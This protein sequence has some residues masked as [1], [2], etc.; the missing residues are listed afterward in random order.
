MLPSPTLKRRAL[1][2]SLAALCTL[3]ALSAL[4]RPSAVA[5][6]AAVAPCA[7]PAFNSA[8]STGDAGGGRAVAFADFN[9][10]G[11]AD[12]AEA[13]FFSQSN[14]RI[15]LGDGAGKFVLSSQ[16]NT[17]DGSLDVTS[18]DFNRDGRADLAVTNNFGST[19]S[20][21]LG[22]GDGTFGPHADFAV[23][24]GPNKL[25][26]GDF[27]G[28]QK[29]DLITASFF[30]NSVTVL[31]GDGAGG[32]S[33]ATTAVVAEPH[34]LAVGDFNGDQKLDAAAAGVTSHGVTV[35]LGNGAGRLTRAPDSFGRL[36][37]VPAALAAVDA[38]ADGRL[39][40]VVANSD[41]RH[42]TVWKGDGAGRFGS[43]VEHP[44]GLSPSAVLVSDLDADGRPDLFVTGGQSATVSVL[45]GKPGGGFAPERRYTV[46]SAP[47]A[48]ALADLNND[49]RTDA[50]VANFASRFLSV[51]LADPSGGFAAAP[52]FS[53][54]PV[55]FDLASAAAAADFNRD[56]KADLA[57]AI[58]GGVAVVLADG[59]GGFAPGPHLAA[60][61]EGDL[62]AADFNRDGKTD[63]AV[64]SGPGSPGSVSVFLGDGAGDFA[65]RRTFLVDTSPLALA[66]ADFNNDGFPD[67]ATQTYGGDAASVL[68]GDGAGG[69]EVRPVNN[70]GIQTPD[71]VAG[72]FNSDGKADLAAT[73]KF[74]DQVAVV[75]GDGAGNFAP[76]PASPFPVVGSPEALAVDDFN[77]DGRAD[78]L[79]A[80]AHSGFLWANGLFL[81]KNNG[82]GGFAA[83]API[84]DVP[85]T[86]VTAGDFNGDGH[87]DF[88]AA[89]GAQLIVRLGNGRGNFGQPFVTPPGRSPTDLDAA[90]MD[91]DG[92]ADL[93]TA[94]GSGDVTVFFN[95]CAAP[96]HAF[97]TL[98]AAGTLTEGDAGTL[99]GTLTFSLSAASTKTVSAG[100]YLVSGTAALGADFRPASGRLIFSPG[101]TTKT[102]SVAVIG[103][104]LDESD[105]SLAVSFSFPLNVVA[106]TGAAT[107]LDNDPAPSAS[108][109]D[110][111]APEG[112]GGAAPVVFHVSLSAPSSRPVSVAY[113]TADGTAQAGA[114]YVATSG[115]LTIRPG[116]TQGSIPVPVVGDG[117][118]EADETF[119][120]NLTAP[121]GVTLADAQGRAT[122]T[123]DDTNVQ[124]E[125][126]GASFAE[127]VGAVAVRVT[128]TGFLSAAS[129][130]RYTTVD[131]GAAG[132]S[133]YIAALGELRFAPDEA[134]KTLTVLVV[135][136]VWAEGPES[137]KVVLSDPSG[138]TLGAASEF[139]A[140]I[141]SDDASTGPSPVG[142]EGFDTRF[143]VTQ[144][145]LDFLNRL[146]DAGGLS[147]WSR[148]ITGC[149]ADRQCVAV[150]RV[151]TSAAFFLSIEFQETGYLVYRM[152][153]AAYGDA[154]SPGVPGTVPVVRLEEFLP[155]TRRI[156]EGVVVGAAGWAER[157]EANKQSFA[158]EFVARPRFLAAYPA[159]LTPAQF[160]DRLDQRA[161]GVLT[162]QE[163]TQL[164]AQLT[165][166]NPA[167]GRAAALRA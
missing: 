107:I 26:R 65:P 46:G 151:D 6:V 148:G 44:A 28:D 29:T 67:L 87:P 51:L 130:V 94:N 22:N 121:A 153:K 48:A 52:N 164:I 134:T 158:Q 92:R 126:A 68:L 157:L 63:L 62:A 147:F 61:A 111:A 91:G 112:T 39:D 15:H 8:L 19:I 123:N 137:F 53:L 103:D 144:H 122:I 2:V 49:G 96:P 115:T 100:Y 132:R 25:A 77:S 35:L 83:P 42:V 166:I 60:A 74:Q 11:K 104:T 99:N 9:G 114:D 98:T 13:G 75:F 119:F 79:V 90:D 105:E 110:P 93:L 118:V 54:A 41:A 57:E 89:N 127:G 150:K 36:P 156:G 160:V 14:L 145:Y 155:D 59:A 82:A 66:V 24:S 58:G 159:S 129:A 3:V 69:F 108:L 124:F 143:F 7:A 136:D 12:L 139:T 1:R 84:T 56:G 101:E 135:N 70:L 88:A 10:D 161:G 165:A 21:L 80:N 5:A 4:P 71:I 106:G 38:D 27:N 30:A 167:G 116:Q 85:Q 117:R 97:P 64:S 33:A 47:G 20:V 162:A 45:K 102:V 138:A 72:D 17:S 50:G 34:A 55:N 131:A 149:G 142:A 113:A 140:T 86:Q 141:E 154:T 133:D 37:W 95:T 16:L 146:P 76:A 23:G 125:A 43:P 78:L 73:L 109:A 32:F 152:Y 40:L 31:L 81:L 120:L 163:R 128:R 18:D